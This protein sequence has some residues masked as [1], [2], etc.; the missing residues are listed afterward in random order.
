MYKYKTLGTIIFFAVFANL[1]FWTR[2]SVGLLYLVQGYVAH[3]RFKHRQQEG[4]V[5]GKK[6]QYFVIIKL[7]VKLN[8][9]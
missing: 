2:S 7:F 8:L 4:R 9:E 1:M 6:D 3:A 5:V